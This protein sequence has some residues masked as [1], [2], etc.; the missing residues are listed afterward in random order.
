[1]E[2]DIPVTDGYYI[3]GVS[4]LEV[5]SSYRVYHSQWYIHPTGCII[6]SAIFIIQ[7]VS[8]LVVQSSYRVY[9]S[10]WYIHH[11]G[12]IILSGN[13][14]YRVYNSQQHIHPTGCIII[15]GIF[16]LQSVSFLVV[17]HPTGCII[18][19]GIFIL[20][21]V[22]FLV[23]Y[24][25]YRVYHSYQ[26][27]HHTGCKTLIY[28]LVKLSNVQYFNFILFIQKPKK[29]TTMNNVRNIHQRYTLEIY[30]RD[31]HQKYTLEIQL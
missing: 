18:F 1:M 12:C 9:H 10:Q 15:S 2:H 31:I 21:C 27:I 19:S 23:G 25:S 4:F 5:Y 20:Q 26:H 3:Q 28:K 22:S 16:I 24:S 14:S 13:S 30:T 11:T 8:F 7:G 17:I 29:T 6:F